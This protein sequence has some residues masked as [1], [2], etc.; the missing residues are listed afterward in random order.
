MFRGYR[1]VPYNEQ[2]YSEAK[3]Q[4]VKMKADMGGTEILAPLK[5]IFEMYKPNKA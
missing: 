1:S 5:A 2:N 4:I 3:S